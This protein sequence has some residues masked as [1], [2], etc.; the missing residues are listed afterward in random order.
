L[1]RQAPFDLLYLDRLTVIEKQ[2]EASHARARGDIGKALTHAREA[3]RFEGEMPYSFGPPF[4][5]FPAAQM[6]GE[7]LLDNGDYDEA[8]AAFAEQLLRSRLK[9]EALVG[10]ARAERGR[11]DAAAADYAMALYEQVRAV[12]DTE[13]R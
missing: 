7:L 11:G 6:L 12:G 1:P 2:L 4:V 3:S 8:A 9:A 5:D 13:S 10:L